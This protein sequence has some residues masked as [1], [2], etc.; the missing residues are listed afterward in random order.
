LTL[1]SARATVEALQVLSSLVAS[2]LYLLCQAFDLRALQSEFSTGLHTV[3][4]E[5]LIATFGSSLPESQRAT[6][7]K[8]IHYAMSVSLEKTT[9]MDSVDRMAAV[10][11]ATTSVFV[12]F[13][14]KPVRFR[15]EGTGQPTAAEVVTLIHNFRS[16][17]ASR[18]VDLLDQ[19][20]KSYLSGERGPAP[21]S[22]YLNKTRP[23]YEFVRITLGIRMHGSENYAY[24]QNGLGVDDVSVGQNISRIYETIRDGQLQPIIVSLFAKLNKSGRL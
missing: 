7:A 9:T 24:F 14:E 13:F 18:C 4:D 12:D 1:I 16:Q 20:R 22:A 15:T 8:S 23:V 19:L 21:A 6:L 5:E 3:V 2:Y 11:A 17:V 10:T